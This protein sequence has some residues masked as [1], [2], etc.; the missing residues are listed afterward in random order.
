MPKTVLIKDLTFDDKGLHLSILFL[1]FRTYSQ[2]I[3][4]E[5]QKHQGKKGI[6]NH[7][8]IFW[9]ILHTYKKIND[10]GIK[11]TKVIQ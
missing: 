1:L 4:N 7:I 5:S 8:L 10:Y 3:Y 6:C 11:N 2:R 9:F